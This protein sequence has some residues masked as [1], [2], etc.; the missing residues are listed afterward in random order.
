MLILVL[1]D[2]FYPP[3]YFALYLTSPS[4]SPIPS[5]LTL[6][7]RFNLQPQLLPI[8]LPT[9]QRHHLDLRRTLALRRIIRSST[10]T[11]HLLPSALRT[12]L[13][14]PLRHEHLQQRHDAG[15]LPG[16]HRSQR[17]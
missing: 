8:H 4:L 1:I 2:G 11:L 17:K 6:L 5:Q 13:L 10:N 7:S 16:K 3:L 14:L 9:Q 15:I 12:P